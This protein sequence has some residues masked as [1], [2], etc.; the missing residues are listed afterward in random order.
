M[1]PTN[2]NPITALHPYNHAFAAFSAEQRLC[3]VFFQRILVQRIVLLLLREIYC[4]R[5][6]I[7]IFDR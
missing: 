4:L 3:L 5:A 1:G 2:V 6:Y 7:A